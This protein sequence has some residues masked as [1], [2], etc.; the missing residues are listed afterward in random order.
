MK[1]AF[2]G[3][4]GFGESSELFDLEPITILTGKNGSGKSTYIKLIELFSDSFANINTVEEL[5]E[6]KID[7][8]NDL[9]GGK[10]NMIH[11]SITPQLIFECRFEFY[12]DIYEIHLNF[13]IEDYFIKLEEIVIYT[14]KTNIRVCTW[15]KGIINCNCKYLYK[16]Y[17]N[18]AIIYNLCK[19]YLYYHDEDKHIYSG[20]YKLT[21]YDPNREEHDFMGHLLKYHICMSEDNIVPYIGTKTDSNYMK[22]EFKKYEHHFKE[23]HRPGENGN[24]IILDIP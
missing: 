10:Q 19:E 17:E 23:L 21:F 24:Y 15:S 13:E 20:D 9:Y 2:R 11:F 7:I 18:K 6:L 3:F 16:E 14:K 12:T 22:F 8:G 1:L 5:F 4:R